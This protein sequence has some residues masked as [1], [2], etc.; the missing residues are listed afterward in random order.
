MASNATQRARPLLSLGQIVATPDAL[1]LLERFGVNAN[2]SLGRHQCGDWG[3]LGVD[4]K[5]CN[6][7]A[8]QDGSLIFSAYRIGKTDDRVWVIT[9]AADDFGIRYLSTIRRPEDY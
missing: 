1:E 8:L 7:E 5:R 4:D 3:E 6:H 2:D 9:D